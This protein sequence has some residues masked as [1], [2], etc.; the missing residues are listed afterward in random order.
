MTQPF[1]NGP[2]PTTFSVHQSGNVGQ[3]II[4]DDGRIIAWTTDE[5][6]AL[7]I[8]RLLNENEE[9]LG[10]RDKHKEPALRL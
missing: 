1:I 4:D 8:C 7:V 5:W 9:L 10:R 2:Q 3:E 6:A